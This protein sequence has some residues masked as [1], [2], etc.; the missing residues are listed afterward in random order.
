MRRDGARFLSSADARDT[1]HAVGKLPELRI[2]AL[3]VLGVADRFFTI[4][5]GRRLADLIPD[6]ALVEVAGGK[7]FLPLDRPTELAAEISSFLAREPATA[8]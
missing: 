4:E 5:D 1:M 7:T 8:S 6:S 3:I 2:P